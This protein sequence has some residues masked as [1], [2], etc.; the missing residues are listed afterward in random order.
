MN[1]NNLQR[2][3]DDR[4]PD[5]R[6]LNI[7]EVMVKYL[8]HWYLFVL[9]V[10]ACLLA[11][12]FYLRYAT[13]VYTVTSEIMIKEDKGNRGSA[14]NI[15]SDL[16]IFNTKSNVQDEIEILKTRYLMKKVVEEMQLNISYFEIGKIKTSDIY[17]KAPFYITLLS[18]NDSIPLQKFQ[19]EEDKNAAFIITNKGISTTHR[20]EDPIIKPGLSMIVHRR[21]GLGFAGHRYLFSI[22]SVN[23]ATDTYVNSVTPEMV[24][25]KSN[26]IQMTISTTVPGKGEAILTKLYEIYT[27]VNREDK[28]R[29]VDST[30]S[31]IN[32][33]L[34]KVAD[35]LKDVESNVEQFKR[36]NNIS[37]D[38]KTQSGFLL[39][40]VSELDKMITDQEVK[41][42]VV[43]SIQQ[44]LNSSTFRVVPGALVIQDPTYMSMVE[45]YNM[46]VLERDNQL[47]TTKEDN[48]FIKSLNQQVL[49]LK[50]D[51][52]TSLSNI[53]RGMGIAKSNLSQK[54][55]RLLGE[56]SLVPSKERAF[57]EISR[58]QNVKQQLYLYLLQKREETAISKSGTLAN[59]RLIEPAISGRV[60]FSPKRSLI[61]LGALV[62]G[63]LIPAGFIYG[64]ELLNNKITSK[65]DI[66]RMTKVPIFG[67]LGHNNTGEI[68]IA[69]QDARTV[70]AE[71]FR[72]MRTNLH[73]FLK[74]NTHQVIL[75]TSSMSGEGKSFLSVNLAL[76][77]AIS[78]KKVV[79]MELDLRKPKVSKLLGLSGSKGFT[80]FVVADIPISSLLQ[81]TTIEPNLFV[82]SA[83]PIPPNP[84]ELIL[85]EKVTTLFDYLRKEFDFIIVDTAP[86]GLVT[87][88]LL[89]SKYADANIYVVRQDYT[90]KDQI[91]IINDL[92][93]NA[94]MAN[95]SIL[96]NDVKNRGSYGYGYGYG[97]GGKGYYTDQP[98]KK[99]FFRK[100]KKGV[101]KG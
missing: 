42:N 63:I 91:N 32:D 65:Q 23:A 5:N 28:N 33:R 89:L 11:A 61:Y 46:L 34:G 95:M 21:P 67:E 16:D 54:K 90:L 18:F 43:E 36:N 25:K 39:E 76:S 66:T 79:L 97:Y 83:G 12:Y 50:T 78:G 45:K 62:L 15:L 35:E 101:D 75:L 96:I 56:I 71:Q 94:K 10:S 69:R 99:S 86:V 17:N 100:R 82:I 55:N 98:E 24:D 72:L 70:L 48:P 13:P 49:N 19:I 87:D 30:I 6:E 77:L 26:V 85:M 73:F 74:G 80:N 4:L 64:K 57:I 9:T 60:P 52:L 8:R 14:Q 22:S 51:L 59:S 93:V 68:I 37:I 40:N 44:H 53:K 81:P 20:F 31:F 38:I 88:A 92:A 47:Q 3:K 7:R 1:E 2:S 41:T 29:I 84:A 58:Q 27:R